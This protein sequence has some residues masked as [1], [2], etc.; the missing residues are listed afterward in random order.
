MRDLEGYAGAPRVPP[1]GGLGTWGGQRSG[2]LVSLRTRPLVGFSASWWIRTCVARCWT[3]GGL[4][5]ARWWI[6]RPVGGLWTRQ[7]AAY[8]RHFLVL[9]VG[10]LLKAAPTRQTRH[11]TLKEYGWDAARRPSHISENHVIRSTFFF[12]GVVSRP[13]EPVGGPS[14]GSDGGPPG[15]GLPIKWTVGGLLDLEFCTKNLLVALPQ[16]FCMAKSLWLCM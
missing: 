10:V 3:V 1:V 11:V 7:W 4:G 15:A 8:G 6:S 13:L 16:I 14:P 12:S 9:A 2:Q 5:L